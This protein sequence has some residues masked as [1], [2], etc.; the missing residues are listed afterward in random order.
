MTTLIGLWS[1]RVATMI[2]N[3]LEVARH[4]VLYTTSQ[5]FNQ[6]ITIIERSYSSSRRS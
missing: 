6:R 5:T 2:I 3:V 1:L 4:T